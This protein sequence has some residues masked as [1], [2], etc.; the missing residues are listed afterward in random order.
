MKIKLWVYKV[1]SKSMTPVLCEEELVFLKKIPFEYLK[2]GDIVGIRT[3]QK[4]YVHRIVSTQKF[5]NTYIL[6]GDNNLCTDNIEL[7]ANNYIG[8]AV[9]VMKN[10]KLVAINSIEEYNITECLINN[11]KM[12]MCKVDGHKMIFKN[13]MCAYL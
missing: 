4:M 3:D 5:G 8:K 6:K 2:V 10:M 1:V 12:Y 11:E 13:N 9:Y 7:N